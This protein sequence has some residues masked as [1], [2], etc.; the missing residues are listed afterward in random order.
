IDS[1]D[2]GGFISAADRVNLRITYG[3]GEIARKDIHYGF[4]LISVWLL[5]LNLVAF[6]KQFWPPALTFFG[7]IAGAA[8]F[9]GLTGDRGAL[10]F[11][12]LYPAWCIWLGR[13]L[14]K[15]KTAG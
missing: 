5:A 4:G 15:N 6:V 12:I 9:I 14:L 11:V 2:A 13:W 1:L 7:L 10:G 8:M 3:L